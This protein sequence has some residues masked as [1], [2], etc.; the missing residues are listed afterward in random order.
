MPS[1]SRLLSGPSLMAE[2]TTSP[3]QLKRESSQSMGYCPTAKVQKKVM[4]MM[5]RNTG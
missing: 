1:Q 4:N 2:P 5:M 3:S